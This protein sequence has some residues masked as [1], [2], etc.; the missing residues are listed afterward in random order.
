VDYNESIL[1][2]CERTLA[3]KNIEC[4]QLN[5][6]RGNALAPLGRQWDLIVS[7]GIVEHLRNDA[8]HVHDMHGA[9]SD[10]G[11]VICVTVLHEWL[12]NDWDRAVGTIV[13][14]HRSV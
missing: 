13:V 10:G 6:D 4:I 1:A 12:F 5:F 3:G 11:M 7:N 8:D 14:I 2:Y 9:L